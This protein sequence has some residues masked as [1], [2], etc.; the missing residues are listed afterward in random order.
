MQSQRQGEWIDSF[1]TFN[2]CWTLECIIKDNI[3]SSLVVNIRLEKVRI[4]DMF[5]RGCHLVISDP[6]HPR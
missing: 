4:M 6:S 2:L 5:W 1:E 3:S